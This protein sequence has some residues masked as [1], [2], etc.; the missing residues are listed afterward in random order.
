M[1]LCLWLK[2]L[3]FLRFF[4]STGYLIRIILEVVNEMKFFL[5]ILMLTVIAFADSL[6][7]ISYSNEVDDQFMEGGFIGATQIVFFNV[8][9]EL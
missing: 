2:L 7:Q 9:G 6:L 3:Y 5:F 4:A 8:L 1:S